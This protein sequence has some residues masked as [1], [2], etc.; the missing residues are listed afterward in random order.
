MPLEAA[1]APDRQP[2]A[3]IFISYSR[4][5][6]AF[7]DRLDAVLKTRGFEPLIDRADIYAFEDWWER[8]KG[9]IAEADTIIFVLSPDAVA[10]Q[11]CAKEIDYAASLNKRF[12]PIVCRRVDDNTVPQPLRR[13]N[14]VFFD[15]PERFELSADK[16]VAALETDLEWIRRQTRFGEQARQWDSVGRPGAHGLLLRPPILDE[17]ET[18]L[19]LKPSTAPEPTE[20]TIAL[21]AASR[22]AYAQEQAR[23][24]TRQREIE[25]QRNKAL[26]SQSLFLADRAN[27]QARSSD[28]ATATLLALEG[29][30]DESSNIDRPYASEAECALSNALQQLRELCVLHGHPVESATFSPDGRRVLTGSRDGTARL[31]D[32]SSGDEIAVLRGHEGSVSSVAFS[33]DGGRVVTTSYDGTA[34]IWDIATSKEIMVLGGHEPSANAAALSLD[35]GRALTVN[36]TA[37]LWD[38]VNG[39]EIAALHRLVSSAMFSPDG[40]RVLT[41]SM[42]MTARLWDAAN[43]EQLAVL[44]GHQA[45]LASAA[46]GPDGQRVVTASG[47]KTA[48]LWDAASGQELAVLRGHQ[49][50][51]QSAV[52]SSDGRCIATASADKTARL[53]DAASGQ[54]LAVLRG[55][56]AAV[57]WVAFSSDTGRVMTSSSDDGAARLW[58]AT[59]GKE[60]AVLRGHQGRVVDAMFGSDARQILTVSRDETARLWDAAYRREIAVLLAHEDAVSSSAF[61]PDG[62]YVVTTCKKTAPLWDAANGTKLAVLAG[63]EDNVNSAAFSPDGRRLLTASE[64]RTARLWD[65]ASGKELVVLRG[66]QR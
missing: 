24:Q 17:A 9:L 60:L 12:A 33:P 16:V 47:D 40:R 63:H 25:T 58:D 41:A 11:I 56:E 4:K 27:Q 30:P 36:L 59:N 52:F 48:R 15:D 10:S 39:N 13:L 18:W 66:H 20:S 6:M 14:F 62:R 38:T 65:S 49:D 57:N 19:K 34:R 42:D 43:G 22:E 54:E 55:H 32:A 31:W 2:K 28:Y 8:I 5:D 7:A 21:I 23:E 1:H 3:K 61:S 35:G 64:D 53:W 46:F 26:L 37:R 29:L 51:V 45:R 44:H 50:A